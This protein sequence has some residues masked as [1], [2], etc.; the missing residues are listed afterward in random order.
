MYN[1]IKAG[2]LSAAKKALSDYHRAE[3]ITTDV[4]PTG[5]DLISLPPFMDLIND[6]SQIKD[7]L[8]EQGV[9]GIDYVEPTGPLGGGT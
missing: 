4:T 5:D 1:L 6:P 9:T 2:G 3:P 7:I 8:E